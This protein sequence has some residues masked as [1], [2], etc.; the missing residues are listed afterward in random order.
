MEKGLGEV[1]SLA[2]RIVTV[3][4]DRCKRCGICVAVCPVKNLAFDD[5]RVASF[6]LCIACMQ[7]EL[8]CPDFAIAVERLTESESPVRAGTA[9]QG[10]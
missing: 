1:V 2:Q 9:E 7:C 5:G 3:R 4:H 8:H 10:R 6:D